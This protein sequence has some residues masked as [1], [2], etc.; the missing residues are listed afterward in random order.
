M[1]WVS[2]IP[3]RTE[4]AAVAAGLRVTY[5]QRVA[6]PGFDTEIQRYDKP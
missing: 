5:R 3:V 4:R 1:V 6:L 2:P